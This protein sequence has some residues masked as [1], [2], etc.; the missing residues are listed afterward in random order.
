MNKIYP[1]MK[2]ALQLDFDGTVTVE[3]I[4]Y[5]LL[6]TYADRNWCE[7]LKDYIDGKISV[8][9]FNKEVFA[10]VKADQQTMLKMV[11]NSEKLLI[12]PGLR[13]LSDFCTEMGYRTIIVSNG[14][15]FYIEAIL[16]NLGIDSIEVYA[17]ENKF[18]RDGICFFKTIIVLKK[19]IPHAC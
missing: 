9:K 16:G 12:R 15:A 3:D 6:D 11:M 5:L 14:L 2:V 18:S 19:H 17:A 7:L 10:M 1:K 8:G 4:S 13:E